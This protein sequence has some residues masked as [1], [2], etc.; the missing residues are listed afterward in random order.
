LEVLLK[1]LK[2]SK[3]QTMRETDCSLILEMITLKKILKTSRITWFNIYLIAL[4]SKKI[5]TDT[6]RNSL[7]DYWLLHNTDAS[8][9]RHRQWMNSAV[10]ILVSLKNWL[11]HLTTTSV[12]RSKLTMMTSKVRLSLHS[13]LQFSSTTSKGDGSRKHSQNGFLPKQ[14]TPIWE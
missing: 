2:A 8:K 5:V 6:K 9:L 13:T 11:N 10:N 4:L 12:Q 1:H 14:D 3:M 7:I